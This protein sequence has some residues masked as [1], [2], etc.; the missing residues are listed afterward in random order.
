MSN[1]SYK[2]TTNYI[3]AQADYDLHES[4]KKKSQGMFTSLYKRYKDLDKIMTL[5][6]HANFG[7]EVA[8]TFQNTQYPDWLTKA[9][10][11]PNKILPDLIK[12]PKVKGLMANLKNFHN[13]TSDMLAMGDLGRLALQQPT[14]ALVQQ[15]MTEEAVKAGTQ[16]TAGTLMSNP[17]IQILTALMAMGYGANKQ[18]TTLNRWSKELGI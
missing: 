6:R 14:S 17:T 10:P 2:P 13:P 16:S 18:G 3:K 11:N 8:K 12:A 7:R 5:T 15:G 9:Y 1:Y 4:D